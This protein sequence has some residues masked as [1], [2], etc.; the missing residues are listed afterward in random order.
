VHRGVHV[1]VFRNLKGE[2]LKCFSFN[3]VKNLLIFI[4]KNLI[5]FVF[6]SHDGLQLLDEIDAISL[7]A[8]A[9]VL[10]HHKWRL[11]MITE[12]VNFYDKRSHCN[13]SR[14]SILSFPILS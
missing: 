2:E 13:C 4:F 10:A 7:E 14:L 11:L 6:K 1:A 5:N 9:V 12:K 8:A 3:S